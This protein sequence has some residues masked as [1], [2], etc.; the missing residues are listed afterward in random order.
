[1]SVYPKKKEKPEA[2]VVFRGKAAKKVQGRGNP[3]GKTVQQPIET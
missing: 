1:M 3:R 2:V